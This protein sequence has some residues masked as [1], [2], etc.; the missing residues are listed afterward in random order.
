MTSEGIMRLLVRHPDHRTDDVLTEP[1]PAPPTR[2]TAATKPQ[3]QD[4]PPP[5]RPR[6]M[7]AAAQREQAYWLISR[8]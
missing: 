3:P 7:S 4:D 6:R 1:V 5:E 2:P 8:H